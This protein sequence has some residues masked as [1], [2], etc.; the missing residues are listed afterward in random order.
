MESQGGL[1]GEGAGHEVMKG[2]LQGKKRKC[3]GGR[4]ERDGRRVGN[5]EGGRREQESREG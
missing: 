5:W 3:K 2:I 4:E 1:P